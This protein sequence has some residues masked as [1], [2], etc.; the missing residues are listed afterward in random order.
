MHLGNHLPS[1]AYMRLLLEE[2]GFRNTRQMGQL[3]CRRGTSSQQLAMAAA[4][5]IKLTGLHA[6]QA[7]VRFVTRI[8]FEAD[9]RS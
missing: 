6:S 8:G 7:S 1:R 4:P 2:P 9:R 5:G 3:G